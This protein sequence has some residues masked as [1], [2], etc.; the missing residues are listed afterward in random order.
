MKQPHRIPLTK[1]MLELLEEAKKYDNG[2]GLVFPSVSKRKSLSDATLSKLIKELRF[3]ADVHDFCTLFRTWAQEKTNFPRELAEMA[4][5][6]N[7]SN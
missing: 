7:I 5:A 4:L 3:E 2:T 6:H 1:R